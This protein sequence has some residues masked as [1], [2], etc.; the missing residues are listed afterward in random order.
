M[1]VVAPINTRYRRL[2]HGQGRVHLV[3]R[4]VTRPTAGMVKVILSPELVGVCRSDLREIVG[5]RH[6]RRDFGHEIVGRVVSTTDEAVVGGGE[7]VVYDPHPAVDRTSGFGELVEIEGTAE[8]VRAA[9]V[10][11]GPEVAAATGIFAEPLACACHCIGRLAAASQL[12]GI[13]PCSRVGIFGAGIAGA[14]IAAALHARGVPVALMNRSRARLDRLRS[15]GFLPAELFSPGTPRPGS[16]QRL[17]VATS[18]AAP[19]I[20]ALAAAAI[21]PGGLM[22]LYAGTRPGDRLGDLDL[23]ATRR[24][25]DTVPVTFA[26]HT[27]TVAGSHGATRADFGQAIR[28][29]VGGRQGPWLLPGA[30]SALVTNQV[31]LAEAPDLLTRHARDGFVG[32]AV[33]T[34]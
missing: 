28:E 7:R 1:P 5:A 14:L 34:I 15:S 22:V 2:E 27:L 23:D 33:I 8:A 18:A 10:P 31:S 13:D 6:L 4:E 25:E 26:G 9:L 19:E 29:L 24:A 17:I 21:A 20:M 30:L 11:L 12:T 16:F 3:A 32:K